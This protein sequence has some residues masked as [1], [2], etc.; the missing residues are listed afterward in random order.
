MSEVIYRT[1]LKCKWYP[2]RKALE[3]GDYKFYN[4]RSGWK[5]AFCADSSGL[6]MNTFENQ[7]GNEY[8]GFRYV[9]DD[10][11]VDSRIC[12]RYGGGLYGC[13]RH[14]MDADDATEMLKVVNDIIQIMESYL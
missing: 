4:K 5:C 12:K 2:L 13:L 3:T 8:L 6:N 10:C 7:I 9:C 11:R 1:S 14:V